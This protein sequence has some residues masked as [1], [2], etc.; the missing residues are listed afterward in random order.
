MLK[1]CEVII[2]T[3]LLEKGYDIKQSQKGNKYNFTAEKDGKIIRLHVIVLYRDSAYKDS[4][5]P[6]VYVMETSFMDPVSQQKRSLSREDVDIVVGYNE[7]DKCFA[8][9]PIESFNSRYSVV[10]HSKPG[11]RHKYFNSWQA[12][13]EL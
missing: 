9:V 13:S 5:L 3:M 12:L 11:T 1:K 6:Q 10:V 2:A 7:E 4:T 8:C